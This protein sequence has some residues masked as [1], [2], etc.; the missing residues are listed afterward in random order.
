MSQIDLLLNIK[1]QIQQ[2]LIAACLNALQFGTGCKSVIRETKGNQS[3]E[4]SLSDGSYTEVY[5]LLFAFIPL[6]L[7]GLGSTHYPDNSA[8]CKLCF[9]LGR[10]YFHLKKKRNQIDLW[11]SGQ[12]YVWCLLKLHREFFWIAQNFR[13]ETLKKK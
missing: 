2:T 5:H 11:G 1:Q 13:I 8:E 10:V 6:Q 9:S 12:T 7:S 4:R 3:F